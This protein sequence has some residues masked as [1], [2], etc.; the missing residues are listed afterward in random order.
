MLVFLLRVCSK[1][2]TYFALSSTIHFLAYFTRA[3]TTKHD[4]ICIPATT[5]PLL[6]RSAPWLLSWP[7]LQSRHTTATLQHSNNATLITHKSSFPP[8]R[9]SKWLVVVF[10]H[11]CSLLFA[12]CV[13]RTYTNSCFL[14]TP[15]THWDTMTAF[16]Q[17]NKNSKIEKQCE[18]FIYNP[19][20]QQFLL[21]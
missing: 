9:Q 8:L 1:R 21:I 3:L 6:L 14:P 18:F 12:H 7:P 16:L 11:V 2:E 10:L 20:L 17:T 4:W 15:Q 5:P 13:A 19:P